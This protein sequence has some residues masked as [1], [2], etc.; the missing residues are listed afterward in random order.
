M[1]RAGV[2]RRTHTGMNRLPIDGEQRMNDIAWLSL[3][4]AAQLVATREVSPVEL[5][6]A[7]LERID[8]LDGRYHSYRTVLAESA[9]EQARQAE[10]AIAE[11]DY[12]GLSLIHL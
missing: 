1:T 10:R 8:A 7:L 6:Q 9:L 11:G 12:L 4:E 5:T 3:T 2:R